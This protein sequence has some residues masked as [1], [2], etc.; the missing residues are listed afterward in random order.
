[1]GDHTVA[2]SA[3]SSVSAGTVAIGTH[4]PI[5]IINQVE[6]ELEAQVQLTDNILLTYNSLVRGAPAVDDLHAL[7]VRLRRGDATWLHVSV[8][9]EH[10]VT[11]KWLTQS[12][13]TAHRAGRYPVDDDMLAGQ[14]MGMRPTGRFA[15]ATWDN[16][17]RQAAG[18]SG[19]YLDHVLGID[20][21][22]N[23]LCGFGDSHHEQRSTRHPTGMGRGAFGT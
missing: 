22:S 4:R 12:C 13:R 11:V 23:Q 2:D 16:H 19:G 1:M 5:I 3:A 20:S 9:P 17:L 18:R 15:A 21:G 14:P 10:L 6:S 8:R 7:K